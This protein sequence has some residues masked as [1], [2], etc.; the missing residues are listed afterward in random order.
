MVMPTSQSSPKAFTLIELLV[1][2]AIIAILMGLL[3]P[4][5]NG[6][7]T[8]ARRAIAKND[9]VQ[10][11]NAVV[12]YETEYGRLPL[13]NKTTVDLALINVLTAEDTTNN[14]RRIVFLE[15]Q[16]ARQGRSGTNAA[17]YLDPWALLPGRERRAY[18]IS[19]DSGYSNNVMVS[20]N[21]TD[22]RSIKILK[23][24]GVWNITPNSREQVRSWD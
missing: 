22:S 15:V 5:V 11:A 4:A 9:V 8:S 10:I 6:A 1:V 21:G 19:M 14:P 16:A 24:V 7:L 23:K 20:T 13:P 3:F 2:I 18:A 12:M 17:G